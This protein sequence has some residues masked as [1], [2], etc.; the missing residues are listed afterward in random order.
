[1]HVDVFK[2]VISRIFLQNSRS[3]E[4]HIFHISH[5]YLLAVIHLPVIPKIIRSVDWF[6]YA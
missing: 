6:L 3:I 5:T 1:M 2:F 4:A